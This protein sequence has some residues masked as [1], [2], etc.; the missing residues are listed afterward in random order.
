[1]RMSV[2]RARACLPNDIRRR[3]GGSGRTN[4]GRREQSWA[5][6][7]TAP[8]R[9][10]LARVQR[11]RFGFLGTRSVIL[12]DGAIQRPRMPI[13]RLAPLIERPQELRRTLA[14]ADDRRNP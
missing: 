7:L 14:A 10:A 3:D 2:T 6:H 9:A 13:V 11:N 8:A 5:N 12:E 4:T 1:M